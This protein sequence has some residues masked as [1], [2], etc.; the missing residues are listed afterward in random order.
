MLLSCASIITQKDNDTLTSTLQE[1]TDP[2]TV[3][4]T[5]IT[6]PPWSTQT[7]NHVINSH[8]GYVM[9]N[10]HDRILRDD[11]GNTLILAK[12]LSP[13]VVFYDNE[14]LQNTVNIN[15]H[16]VFNEIE[17]IVNAICARYTDSDAES[18]LSDPEV[19]ADYCLEYYTKEA[20]SVKFCI[21]ETDNNA[22]THISYITYNLDL[23][24]GAIINCSMMFNQSNLDE[25]CAL[26]S[27]KLNENGYTLF[28]DSQKL[29]QKYFSNRWYIEF[30][31]LNLCF[32]PGEISAVSEGC[33]EISVD[34]KDISSML[35]QYGKAI[36]TVQYEN[37]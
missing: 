27:Q 25:V 32:N 16:S 6:L 19:F 31:K 15:L 34:V 23:T 21:T 22:Q 30:G 12:I 29:I 37:N 3:L 14:S 8:S 24:T 26:V 10:V 28:D 4:T 7:G 17:G 1:T 13:K 11:E 18:F 35:S 9:T 2:S 36:F 33:I 20:M 5:V